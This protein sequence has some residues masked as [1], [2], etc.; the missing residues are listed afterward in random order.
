MHK[1]LILSEF[2]EMCHHLI[3]SRHLPDLEIVSFHNS[4]EMDQP[5]FDC[6]IALGDPD[7]LSSVITNLKRLEWIQSTWAG[8]K[9]LLD[10]ELPR[11]YILT[12]IKGVFGPMISEFVFCYML[13][14]EKK[15]LAR[16]A[17]QQ[18]NQWNETSPGFLAGKTMGIMGV[19]SI[20]GHIAQTAKYFGMNTKGVTR[21]KQNC[22]SID[23]YYHLNQIKEFVADLDY[24][25]SVLPHTQQTNELI[26]YTVLSAM[27][28]EAV[29]INV[30]RGN[31][32]HEEALIQALNERNLAAAVL[33]VFQE[34][35]LPRNHPFWNTRNLLV[36]SHTAAPSI[37]EDVAT[38][39]CENYHNFRQGDPLNYRIDFE[40]GY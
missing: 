23:H 21:R 38:V 6:N 39:F 22:Q 40:Q 10:E 26:D 2:A 13:M 24:L 7:L 25:V 20:G 28:K 35:P 31:V 34:E 1:L 12:N 18:Q 32:I 11:N 27:K 16:Y 9:P 17:S 33:D 30:G 3:K 4:K 37:P 14:H 5:A 8:I 29:I 19:G 36:T 15:A